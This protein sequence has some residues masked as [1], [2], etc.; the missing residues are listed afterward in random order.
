MNTEAVAQTAQETAI[1]VEHVRKRFGDV[2][3]FEDIC[4][5]F[6]HGEA[7]VLMGASGSGKTTL[8]RMIM[9]LESPDEGRIFGMENRRC[10][11]VFQED[12]LC[13]NLSV[14]AN[15]RM[16]H[17]GL[18]G[19]E[20]QRFL[21]RCEELLDAMDMRKTLTRPVHELS[22]GMKRR[23]ALARAV[24]ADADVLFFDEPLKGLDEETERH[25]MTAIMPLLGGKTVF[26][27]THREGELRYFSS[28]SL[29]RIENIDK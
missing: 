28:P 20:K 8:L 6:P 25:V 10:A 1:A 12:R 13:E 22:G 19:H 24:L 14:A 21:Q 23:V 4:A 18:K 15:I 16:P 3:V 5:T 26:W 7:H 2:V 9:G 27:A 29:T 11:A 17:A